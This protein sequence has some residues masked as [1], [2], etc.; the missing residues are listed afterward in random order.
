MSRL[1]NNP[2]D[3]RIFVPK[4]SGGVL[5]NFGHPVAWWIVISTTVIPVIVVV[6]VTLAVIL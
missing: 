6:G 1:Y 5:L 3:K 2:D 4:K